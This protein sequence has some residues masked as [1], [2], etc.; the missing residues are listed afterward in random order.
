MRPS[1]GTVFVVVIVCGLVL[2][3]VLY[4]QTT[5]SPSPLCGGCYHY[6]APG[7]VVTPCPGLEALNVETSQINSPTNMTLTIRNSGA[8]SVG[9]VSYKV[10]YNANQFTNMNPTEPSI[11]INQVAAINIA[12]DG[13]AFTFQSKNSYTIVLTTTRNN[14][15][16]FTITA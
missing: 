1:T 13:N 16:T 7:C 12:I 9:F 8:A 11:G 6:N 15:F 4:W 2:G 5:G 14:I 3:G 10:Q